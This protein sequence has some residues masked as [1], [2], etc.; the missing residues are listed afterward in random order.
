MSRLVWAPAAQADL[1]RIDGFNVRYDPDFADRMGRA[2]VSAG[3]FLLEFPAAGAI[4]QGDDRKWK[5]PGTDYILVYRIIADGVEI[6][7]AY[8]ARE[9]WRR[10]DP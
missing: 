9:D 4:V 1:A 7:R 2:A 6:V 3:R 8:H 5:V 10:R